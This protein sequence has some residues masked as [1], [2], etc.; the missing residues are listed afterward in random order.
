M[1]L[2]DMVRKNLKQGPRRKAAAEDPKTLELWA[3]YVRSEQAYRKEVMAAIRA[4]QNQEKPGP[5]RP[6]NFGALHAARR[7]FE[8]DANKYFGYRPNVSYASPPDTAKR[9][10]KEDLKQ[11]TAAQLLADEDRALKDL[12]GA[13][14]Q[15]EKHCKKLNARIKAMR[16]IDAGTKQA[17]VDAVVLAQELSVT[18]PETT[19]LTRRMNE[20]QRIGALRN[21]R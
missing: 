1:N 17:I 14:N 12:E 8:K 19:K 10:V 11:G 15:V 7:S 2:L 20:L 16:E 9:R 21:V 18:G 4:M 5:R 3:Q 6:V 13:R